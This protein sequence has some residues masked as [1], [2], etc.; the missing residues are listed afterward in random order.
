MICAGTGSILTVPKA[1]KWHSKRAGG[2]TKMAQRE[3][4][5]C[6]VFFSDLMEIPY[7]ERKGGSVRMCNVG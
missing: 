3:D 4:S 7:S 6:Q 2:T 1:S 5:N